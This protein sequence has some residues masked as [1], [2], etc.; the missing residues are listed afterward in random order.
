MIRLTLLERRLR[1]ATGMVLAFYIAVHLTNH[2]LGLVSLDAMEAMRRVVTPFWR[3]AF[4][5]VLLYG[6]LLTHFALALISLYRRATLRMPAWEA[7]QLGL[8]L[9]IV[10]LLASHVASTFGARVLLGYD[11][12]YEYA[13]AGI[14][15]YNWELGKQAVLVL[16]AWGH[17][18][19]GLHFFFRLL[20]GYRAWSLLLY[21]IVIL[22]PLL[23]ALSLLRVGNDL[24]VWKSES[25]QPAY[26][27]RYRLQYLLGRAD[28]E[29]PP[30]SRPFQPANKRL[31]DAIL[32][33]F[34]GLLSLTLLARLLRGQVKPD[35]DGAIVKHING[36]VLEGKPGQTILEIV[37]SHGI[38]HASLCGGRARCT[39]CRVRVGAGCDALDP[40]SAL[41][42][43]ALDRIGAAPNVRLACQTRPRGEIQITPLLPPDLDVGG[44]WKEGGVSGE[45][46]DVVALFV[47]LRGS[48]Q[49]STRHLPY[50]VLFIL[51]RFFLE[52]SAVL[53][54]TDGHYAQFEGDGL[55]AL[56]GLE[57]SLEQGCRDA[58]AGAVAMQ[59]RVDAINR[60]LA[61]EL[62]EPLRIGIGVHCGPAIV[63]TMGPPTSPNYSAIGDC[64]NAAARL[65]THS[66]ALECVAII[67]DDVARQAGIDLRSFPSM[68]ISLHGKQS[69][70][71]AY[72]IRDPK[73]I[74]V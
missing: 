58:F 34:W 52:M 33:G 23:V 12:N 61:A 43:H 15:G 57:R 53:N 60:E 47:D 8:G 26:L 65:E 67:S 27:D 28:S 73:E 19:V 71:V 1:I 63:G 39:T 31:R 7:V 59:A 17:A 3:S 56:Y 5:S 69:S 38:P 45:E 46:R 11:I 74:T 30:R 14:L 70:V 16:I 41:E 72:M 49:Y 44:R 42:Q 62:H 48:S 20:H 13:L 10:P 68:T 55:L 4:G 25:A 6:S 21:P 37:R 51:N 18:V 36:R 64:V 24:Q 35:N 50:D 2:S 32:I 9:A 40:P 29:A 22:L 54:A 66:K